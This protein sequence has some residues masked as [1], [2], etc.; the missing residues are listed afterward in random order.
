MNYAST[1]ENNQQK[2]ETGFEDLE[3]L[4]PSVMNEENKAE[5]A[6]GFHVPV[7]DPQAKRGSM[8]DISSYKME[9]LFEN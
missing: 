5:L 6:T 2:I 1:N 4:F 9:N 7:L 8:P 3:A